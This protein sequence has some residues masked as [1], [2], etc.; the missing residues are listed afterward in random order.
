MLFGQEGGKNFLARVA[1][2]H[3]V[4]PCSICCTLCRRLLYCKQ[5][6]CLGHLGILFYLNV[7]KLCYSKVKNQTMQ[8]WSFSVSCTKKASPLSPSFICRSTGSP[9]I[10]MSTCRTEK[11]LKYQGA[12]AFGF[13]SCF[14]GVPTTFSRDRRTPILPKRTWKGEHCREPS[15]CLTT[16]TSMQPERVAG[17]RPRYSSFT[18][19]NTWPANWPT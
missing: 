14:S 19:T 7:S 12:T 18:W 9:L 15:G 2:L 16:M 1:T 5:W 11:W 13:R 3:S 8:T 17:L 6:V 4:P 10:S